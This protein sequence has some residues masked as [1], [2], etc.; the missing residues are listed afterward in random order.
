MTPALAEVVGR[1]AADLPQQA[2]LGVLRERFNIRPGVATYRNVVRDLAKSVR[3]HHDEVAIERLGQLFE[4][5]RQSEGKHE[6]LLQVGRDGVFVQ[7][8]PDWEEASC[9]T[10]AVYDRSCRRLGTVYL[11]QMPESDQ[12]TMTARLTHL[13]TGTLA[14]L[15]GYVPRLR[16]LTDAGYHPQTYFR[17]VL[18]PM[19][20]PLDGEPLDWS[21]GVDFYHACEYITKLASALFGSGKRAV[22]WA[23]KQRRTLRKKTGGVSRVIQSAAQQKRRHGLHGTKKD[24]DSGLNYLKKY[25]PYMDFAERK[26]AGEPIGSGITEA[27][28]KVIFNQRL[29]QSGM[30][31]HG[32]TG[33]HIVDLRTAVRGGIWQSIWERILGQPNDL[34]PI[35]RNQTQQRLSNSKETT[36]LS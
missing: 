13:I 30:R 24:Y 23:H 5:A 31:W 28:C 33:Q 27:G 8:R 25:R 21:W 4:K 11:G 17:H 14:N 6:P 32:E 12:P 18:E 19:K 2:V 10:L 7:T 29:K 16:Y 9:G 35:T 34:P 1:L 22:D 36:L 15:G 20:H 3:C 26:H